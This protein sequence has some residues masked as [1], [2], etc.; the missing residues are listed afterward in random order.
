MSRNLAFVICAGGL[1]PR[2]PRDW[3]DLVP[4]DGAV[5]ALRR[6][7][8]AGYEIVV[9]GS[10]APIPGSPLDADT[11]DAFVARLLASQ[12]IQPIEI[13]RCAHGAGTD[14]DCAPPGL[15]LLRPYI[16][17]ASLDRLRS[18]VVGGDATT[19]ALA[20]NIGLRG[21]T[22]GNAIGTDGAIGWEAVA[23]AV[24][25]APRTA[26]VQRRTRETSIQVAVD[27]D[28]VATP[29]IRTGI[30]FFDHMLEQLGKHGGFA[31]SVS[32]DGDL[33]VDEHHTVEDVALAIGEALRLALGAK[34]GIGRYGFVLP[35]DEACAQVSVDLSGRAYF[36]FDGDFS[37]DAVGGLPTE[38]VPHFF[39]SI[40]DALGATLHLQ[41]LGDNDHHKVEASFKGFARALRQAFRREG[42]ELPSTKGTL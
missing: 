31:L 36:V 8:E 35:M 27:L 23:H 12:G 33:E 34:L 38:L 11:A 25:D 21:F 19:A 32:C 4:V 16:G 7:C 1:L 30:G 10:V 40:S 5:A 3:T 28:R 13:A 41:V 6:L 22:I 42:D 18:I 2:P 15:G 29:V 20:A 39:R 24:L 9:L 26:T 37:R 14:C 17:D